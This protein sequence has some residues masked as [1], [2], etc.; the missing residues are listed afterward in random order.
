MSLR[1]NSEEEHCNVL[2]DHSVTGA[3]TERR[4][5]ADILGVLIGAYYKSVVPHEV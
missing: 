3:E 1:T 5:W 2:Q 4:F